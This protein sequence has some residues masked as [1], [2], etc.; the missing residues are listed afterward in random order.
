MFIYRPNAGYHGSRKRPTRAQRT[1]VKERI[2][3]LLTAAED[4]TTEA[5]ASRD[6]FVGTVDADFEMMD[7]REVHI[8]ATIIKFGLGPEPVIENR[9]AA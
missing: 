3:A 6:L 7:E 2:A 4:T 1:V 8:G 9:E 5:D